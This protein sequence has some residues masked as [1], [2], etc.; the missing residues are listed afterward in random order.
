[1]A[2]VYF[3]SAV[4]RHSFSLEAAKFSNME[5]FVLIGWNNLPALLLFYYGYTKREGPQHG[6]TWLKKCERFYWDIMKAKE[7]AKIAELSAARP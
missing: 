4:R 7:V 2:V 3:A 1:M 5:G 6:H